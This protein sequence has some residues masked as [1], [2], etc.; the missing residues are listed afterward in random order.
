MEN[1]VVLTLDEQEILE[2]CHNPPSTD[3]YDAESISPIDGL[4]DIWLAAG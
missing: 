4:A 2:F 1:G 3:V